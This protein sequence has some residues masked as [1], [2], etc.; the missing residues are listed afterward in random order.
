MLTASF[1]KNSLQMCHM[2]PHERLTTLEQLERL[3]GIDFSAEALAATPALPPTA[4]EIIMEAGRADALPIK[5]P[6]D[7]MED[8]EI[9]DDRSYQLLTGELLLV[10]ILACPELLRPLTIMCG[11]REPRD[12]VPARTGGMGPLEAPPLEP[13]P[14]EPEP[15]TKANG[16]GAMRLPGPLWPTR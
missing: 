11:A 12:V 14:P 9:P 13:D 16:S 2:R 15:P 1:L 7:G 8:I 5:C 10:L 4:V 6:I 3:V